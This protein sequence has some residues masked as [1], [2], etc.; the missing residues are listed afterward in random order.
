[1]LH[2]KFLILVLLTSL[3]IL[4][5][6]A[7]AQPG[8]YMPIEFKRAYDNGTRTWDGTVSSTYKQNSSRYDISAVVDPATRQLTASGKI[9]YFNYQDVALDKIVFHSYKDLYDDGMII[10]KLK[11]DGQEIDI[12]DSKRVKKS[13]TYYNIS[14]ENNPLIPGDSLVLKVD[15]SIT[16][17]EKVDR[18]GAYD[19]TSMLV[20]YW[21][22][23]IAV[24]DD[25]FGWDMIDFDGKAEFYHDVSDFN[26]EITIPDNYIIWA[27]AAPSNGYEI[28]PGKIQNRL[29]QAKKSNEKVVIVSN[30]DIKKGLKM[31]TNVW[32]YSLEDFPDF[33]FS[34]SDHYLWEACTYTDEMG[35]YFLNSAYHPKNKSFGLVLDIEKEGLQTFHNDFP[36]HPFPY[37]HFVAFNGE[38]GGGMEFPGMC[39]DHARA[40][41]RAEGVP[42]SDY[43]AN[44]LLTIHEMMHMYF[45]FLMGIN[46]KRF[47]WMD[48]GMA[49]FAEDY[50]TNVNLE[51]YKSRERFASYDNPPLMVQTYSIPKNYGVNSYDIASQSYHALLHLL[52]KDTFTR[53]LNTFMDRWKNKHPTPYDFFFTFDDVSGQ[54]LTWFWKAWYFDWGYPDVAIK[55]FKDGKLVIENV[56]G[57]PIAVEIHITYQDDSRLKIMTSPEVWKN[58]SLYTT[59]I[60]NSIKIKNIELKTMNGPD[61]I[62]SNNHWRAE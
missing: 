37:E 3:S 12:N 4:V 32:K 1:M 55:S 14:L 6:R 24:F 19:E 33:V 49:E 7:L 35:T 43:E 18:D 13:A 48:E 42:Y 29:G 39:N 60:S 38:I 11:I 36:V 28:F 57:R 46:E 58:K 23:E 31:R 50:F 2:Q 25:V 51:S 17:P 16:I 5:N 54:D 45:P 61:A 26:I 22:P 56:G 41:Y 9:T 27:S 34:F 52:G 21:Y 47:A 20:A 8:L 10:S 30:K 53:C 15:W 59:T 44:K 62:N 40:N